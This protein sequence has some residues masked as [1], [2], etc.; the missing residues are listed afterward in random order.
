MST[1]SLAETTSVHSW[2]GIDWTMRP[3]NF[4]QGLL[5]TDLRGWAP[6]SADGERVVEDL[7]DLADATIASERYKRGGLSALRSYSDYQ[8]CRFERQL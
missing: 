8:A 4:Q 3:T 2:L 6:P 7:Q 1:L 5:P